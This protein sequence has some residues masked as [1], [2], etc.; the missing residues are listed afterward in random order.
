M[1]RLPLRQMILHGWWP[2]AAKIWLYRLKG[3][4]IGKG[5][6][7]SFG[8]ILEGESVDIGDSVRLGL[9][10]FVRGKTI[11]LGDHVQI[12]ATSMLD[13][14]HLEIGAGTTEVRKLIISGEL[15]KRR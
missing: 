7:L 14:P 10:S 11:R 15:L 5:V 6:H 4:R 3:Y 9:L 12:G 13:T 1:K 8:A 2:S